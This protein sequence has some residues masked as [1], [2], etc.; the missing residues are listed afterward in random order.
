MCKCFLC[1]NRNG[2]K[3]FYLYAEADLRGIISVHSKSRRNIEMLKMPYSLQ[4]LQQTSSCLWLRK[5]CGFLLIGFWLC[6]WLC[7]SENIFSP[8][9]AFYHHF[10]SPHSWPGLTDTDGLSLSLFLPVL[11]ERLLWLRLVLSEKWW[12]EQRKEKKPQR[13]RAISREASLPCAMPA[14][15]YLREISCRREIKSFILNEAGYVV[16]WEGWEMKPPIAG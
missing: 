6:L 14:L 5:L 11:E 16:K 3:A 9:C 13:R 10:L 7:V 15:E 4:K 12:R 8:P 1:C 2:E